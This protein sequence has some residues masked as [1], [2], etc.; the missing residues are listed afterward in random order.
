[1]RIDHILAA[2]SDPEA[3]AAH[4]RERYGLGT[5]PGPELY[6][7]WSSRILPMRSGQYL[8]LLYPGSDAGAGAN[9]WARWLRAVPPGHFEL[10]GWAVEVGDLDERAAALAVTPQQQVMILGNGNALTWRCLADTATR[11]GALPYF[12]SY[13]QPGEQRVR[14]VGALA[15]AARHA[16]EP[17][18]FGKVVTGAPAADVSR[19]LGTRHPLCIGLVDRPEALQAVHI[20]LADGTEAIIRSH[21][22]P[23]SP[24]TRRIP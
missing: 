5:V 20:H 8:Q 18:G 2:V 12:V 9:P 10:I 7:G 4:L 23:V 6:G 13:E 17:L 14:L 15:A 19:W 24:V 16:V 3:S 1:M 11:I 22:H 21:D